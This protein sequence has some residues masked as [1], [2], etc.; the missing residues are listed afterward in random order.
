[1]MNTN[2]SNNSTFRAALSWG[3]P[4]LLAALAGCTSTSPK[5][6]T[7]FGDSLQKAKEAQQIAPTAAQRKTPAPSATSAEVQRAVTLQSLGIS[8]AV[9]GGGAAPAQSGTGSSATTG[10]STTLR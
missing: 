2:L 7:K 8:G 6:D 5:L 4:I 9:V 10:T 3:A 1:M